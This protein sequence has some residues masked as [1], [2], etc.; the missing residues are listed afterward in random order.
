MSYESY[1]SFSAEKYNICLGILLGKNPMNYNKHIAS[2]S[3]TNSDLWMYTL[4]LFEG[5]IRID[6]TSWTEN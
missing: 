5:N 3:S 6:G 1:S 2:L 4:L